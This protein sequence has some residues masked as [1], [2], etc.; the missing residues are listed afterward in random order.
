[1]PYKSPVARSEQNRKYRVL[2]IDRL[3]LYDKNRVRPP[4]YHVGR[5]KYF[6]SWY[7]KNKKLADERSTKWRLSH[8]ERH[9]SFVR[10]WRDKNIDW[11]KA[12][13]KAYGA[14]NRETISAKERAYRKLHINQCRRHWKTR[15][16]KIRSNP[17]LLEQRRRQQQEY[18]QKNRAQR[19][20]SASF[21]AKVRRARL[22]GA[23]GTFTELQWLAR[24]EFYGCCCAYCHV[25]LN[26]NS[27]TIDHVI[28]ISA[29][30]SNWPSNLVP[31]CIRCNKSKG[32]RRWVPGF[33]QTIK[34]SESG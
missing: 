7:Q 29:G 11:M 34:I 17:V 15:M 8:P 25:E 14:K 26:R 31:A 18:Y 12:Y 21:Y 9:R 3:R 10:A 1:M 6:A 27:A 20:A 30:G 2:N 28:P 5:K 13:T 32:K 4:D 23:P 33:L 16:D 22:A 19:I 24:L